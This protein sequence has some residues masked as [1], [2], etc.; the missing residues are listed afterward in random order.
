MHLVVGINGTIGS[1]LFEH[2][3]KTANPVWGTTQRKEA[4]KLESIT[5]LNLRDDKNNW[6]LPKQKIDVAYLCAGVCRMA[7]C[8]D[9]PE[10]TRQVNI[11]GMCQLIEHL[12]KQGT[13]I[14]YLSTNQVFSGQAAHVPENALCQPLNEYGLQKSIVEKFIQT[15]AKYSAIVRLTKVIEPHMSLVE[16][17]IQSLLQHQAIHVFHDMMLAPVALRQVIDVLIAVGE[18]KQ[19]GIYAVSG[20]EDVSYQDIAHYLAKLLSVPTELVIPSSALENGLKKNFL[21]RFTSMD[22]SSTIALCGLQPP[23][24]QEVLHECFNLDCQA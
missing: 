10:G 21:P 11:D 12:S 17:W 16:Q 23:R 24:F 18:K 20:E 5:Y 4:I 8:E 13:F 14:I 6:Q 3:Q 1:A 9:D 19:P 2:L 7:Q 22:C 15:H